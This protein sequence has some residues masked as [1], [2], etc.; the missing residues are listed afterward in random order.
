MNV[1]RK[2]ILVVIFSVLVRQM[3][4]LDTKKLVMEYYCII[5]IV[6]VLDTKK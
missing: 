1:S 4:V 6:I 5:V 2:H 3:C